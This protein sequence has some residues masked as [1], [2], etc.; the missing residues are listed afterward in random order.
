MTVGWLNESSESEIRRAL[1]TAM[2]ELREPRLEI[3]RRPVTSNPLYWSESA[4]IDG[5]FVMKFAWSEPRAVRLR[6]ERLLLER[7]GSH[8]PGLRVPRLV[9][10]SDDPVVMVTALIGGEPLSF[11]AAGALSGDRLD[12]VGTELGAALAYLHEIPTEPLLD[13]LFEVVPTPQSDTTALRERFGAIVDPARM[14]VVLG[15]CDW[16]DEVL[17]DDCH[18]Q[19]FVHGDLHGYNQLWNLGT[20]ELLALVDLEESGRRDPHFD[21]RYLAGN[22]DSPALLLS[23]IDAYQRLRSAPVSLERA[24]CWH[25]LTHLGD[26]LWRTEAGVE[27]PV[28]GTASSWVDDLAARLD[29]LGLPH[30]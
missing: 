4:T 20:G 21:F 18:A 6:R 24:M 7:L 10:Y 5:R 25:V 30:G 2:P 11:E 29:I 17:S 16:V 26:A 1:A 23:V 3:R 27:L 22:S 15:W 14:E 12:R 19:A 8:V 13:G 28:G 9:A